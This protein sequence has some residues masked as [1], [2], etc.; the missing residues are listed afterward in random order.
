MIKMLKHFEKGKIE[1]CTSF[2]FVFA[3][4]DADRHHITVA[5]IVKPKLGFPVTT[6]TLLNESVFY[7]HIRSVEKATNLPFPLNDILAALFSKRDP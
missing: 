4:S 7:L 3:V 6:D 1:A 5:K 2:L